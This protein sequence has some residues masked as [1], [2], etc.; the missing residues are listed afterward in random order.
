LESLCPGNDARLFVTNSKLDWKSPSLNAKRAPRSV[1]R[2][3]GRERENEGE[4]ERGGEGER[5]REHD[6]C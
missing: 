5:G 2:G 3:V 4:W 6:L 1:L